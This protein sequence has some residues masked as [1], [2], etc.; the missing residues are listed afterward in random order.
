[1]VKVRIIQ[2][3]MRQFVSACVDQYLKLSKST[4]KV[5][6]KKAPTP[7]LAGDEKDYDESKELNGELQPIAANV[8]MKILCGARMAGYDLLHSCQIFA[9]KIIKWTKRCDQRLFQIV[10][11]LHQSLE[12]TM[13]GWVGDDSKNW[14]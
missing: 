12:L 1:M 5:L 6:Q 2:Y 9:C 7:Y 3:D 13:F 4:E 8:I 11:Y 14:R 10:S